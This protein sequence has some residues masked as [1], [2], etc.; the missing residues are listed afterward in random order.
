MHSQFESGNFHISEIYTVN[1]NTDNLI[2]F[3]P[4]KEGNL[5]IMIKQPILFYFQTLTFDI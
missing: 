2:Q 5:K 3:R 1:H 4:L